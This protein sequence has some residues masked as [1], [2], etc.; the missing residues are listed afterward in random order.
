MKLEEF[1]KLKVGNYVKYR[2]TRYIIISITE[3]PKIVFKENHADIYN[4]TTVIY[5]KPLDKASEAFFTKSEYINLSLLSEEDK[6]E[7]L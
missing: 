5:C 3:N 1:E 4:A 2:A 6:I 7:L